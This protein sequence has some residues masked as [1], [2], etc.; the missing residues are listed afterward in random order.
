MHSICE[1]LQHSKVLMFFLDW[2]PLAVALEVIHYVGIFIMV[3][4]VVLVDLRVLGIAAQKRKVGEFAAQLFPY[5][6]FG[7]AMIVVSGFLMFTSQAAD[8]YVDPTFHKKMLVMVLAL[9]A[10]LFIRIGAP[11]WERTGAIPV[12]AKVVALICIVLMFESI[13]FG[14]LVPAVSGIG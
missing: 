13:I 4:S 10:A 12:A 11:R 2:P 1:W 8:Y 5:A 7:L 3:G 6:W 14:N 9:L